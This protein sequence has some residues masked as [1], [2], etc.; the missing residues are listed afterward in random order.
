VPNTSNYG[1]DYESPSSLP[2]VT[3]TGGPTTSSPVLAVQVDAALAST[4]NVV[5][6][7][8]SDIA[9]LEASVAAATTSITDLTNWSR[10]GSTSFTFT[11]QSSSTTGVN[12]GFTFPGIPTV[13]AQ[14]DTGVGA[15]ARWEARAISINASGFI[16][17]VYSSDATSDTWTDIPVSYMA[18]YRA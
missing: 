6:N 9:A 14:I 1:F 18:L 2:G 12:F 10:R 5:S 8:A 17:F 16:M 7:Q 11:S 4:D 3:L 13:M 15:T